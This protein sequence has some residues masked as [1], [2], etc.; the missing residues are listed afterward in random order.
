MLMRVL[1]TIIATTLF[2]SIGS[3]DASACPQAHGA[4]VTCPHATTGRYDPRSVETV[5][6]TIETMSIVTHKRI[7][8]GVQLQLRTN[9]GKTMP[10]HLGPSW[11]IEN[12]PLKLQVGD[13]ITVRGSR[14]TYAD[15]PAL[16][17]AE[18]QRGND[19]LML[20]DREGYPEWYSWRQ[21]AEE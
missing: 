13:E 3:A 12:Q 9:D 16:I 10:V 1:G 17:A 20:R 18:V 14:I 15:A 4:D 7:S 2:A 5:S 19:T 11:F 21:S 6:G 8:E